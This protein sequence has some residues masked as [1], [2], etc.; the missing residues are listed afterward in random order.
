[1]QEGTAGTIETD[2]TETTSWTESVAPGGD[3]IF[4][5]VEDGFNSAGHATWELFHQLPGHG[6]VIGGAIGLGAAMLVGVAELATACFAGYVSYRMFGYGEG[7][8]E[9][10][11]NA[12]RFESGKFDKEEIDRPLPD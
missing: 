5:T 10:I 9:A 2:E 1:M 12:I 8:C 4:R 3:S 11:E 6:A 7:L